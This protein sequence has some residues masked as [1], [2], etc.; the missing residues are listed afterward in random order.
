MSTDSSFLTP[1]IRYRIAEPRDE[2]VLCEMLYWAVFV[3]VG[4]TPPDTSVVEQ[5]E[6]AR[7]VRDWGRF[8]DDGVIAIASTGDPVG[9]A[10]L[11]LWSEDDQ[12]Y[13]FIGVNTP[14]LCLAV[15]AAFR[16]CGIGTRM[17]QEILRRADQMHEVVS[18]SVSVQNPAVRLYERCGFTTVSI[19]G[20]SM[21]MKRMRGASIDRGAADR[22]GC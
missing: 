21:T 11:R 18:L 5:L 1:D 13:G 15:R 17:L 7:Y 6:L 22:R 20:P 10:W 14:E 12:G 2:P 4:S 9:A 16:G 19:D 8:G 3:P